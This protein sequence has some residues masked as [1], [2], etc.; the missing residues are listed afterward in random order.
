M[1]R[2]RHTQIGYTGPVGFVLLALVFVAVLTGAGPTAG[3]LL[4]FAA[5]FALLT[6]VLLNFS[7]L[8]VWIDDDTLSVAFGRG[9]PIKTFPLADIT[10]AAPMR[11]RMLDG[12]GIRSTE[13]GLMYNVWG[14]QS[15]L[16]N[17]RDGQSFR[18][19]TDEPTELVAVLGSVG[20]ATPA[21]AWDEPS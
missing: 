16:I 6:A 7:R 18:I 13:T 5:F 14:L 8:T 17:L 10:A 15:V 2:Y 21:A 3:Q 1:E 9:W 11:N 12:F 20:V 19:G 4:G